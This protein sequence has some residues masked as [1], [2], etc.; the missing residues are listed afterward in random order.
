MRVVTPRHY[1]AAA[2]GIEVI[3]ERPSTRDEIL[4]EVERFFGA[5]PALVAASAIDAQC[6]LAQ[7]LPR[8]RRSCGTSRI[9]AT[10]A[11]IE[12]G[13]DILVIKPWALGETSQAKAG[14]KMRGEP[15]P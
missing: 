7:R 4:P 8:G 14:A 9:V 10:T 13:V 6:C 2:I 12:D 5:M 1:E 3:H 11:G 15:L